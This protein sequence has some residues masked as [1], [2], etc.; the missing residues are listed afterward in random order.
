MLRYL[1]RLADR[2]LALDRTDDP[3]R[4]VHHEAERHH[5]DDPG[6]VARVLGDAPRSR[7][8]TQAAGYAELFAD[9]EAALVRDHR[10][11]AVSLQPNAGSQGELAGLRP[12]I[13]SF[14]ASGERGCAPSASSRSRRTAPTPPAR[15]WRGCSVVVVKCDDDG[16]VDFDDLKAKANAHAADLAALMVTYRQPR[17]VRGEHPRRVHGRARVRRPGVPRR[18]QPQRAVGVAKPGRVGADVS[19]LNLHK[20][21]CIPHG[22]GGPGVGPVAVRSHLAAHLPEHVSGAPCTDRR[23]SCRSRPPT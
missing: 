6:D 1:R 7:R 3:A 18:R 13:R 22:G 5:R 15:S 4:V 2:D 16:N 14:H 23:A 19:H 10:V 17:R 21:F 20:T 11:R 12:A 9:L 8:S